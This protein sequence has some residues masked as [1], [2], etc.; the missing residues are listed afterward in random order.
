MQTNNEFYVECAKFIQNTILEQSIPCYLIG[1]ALINSLR[2]GGKLL[3]DDIDFAVIV[4]G[5]IDF[6]I[7]LIVSANNQTNN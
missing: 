5:D 4:E 1:G 7:S 3:T 6:I 2:D